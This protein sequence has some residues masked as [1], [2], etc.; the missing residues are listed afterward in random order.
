M[1]KKQNLVWRYGSGYGAP[2]D[3]AVAGSFSTRSK[4]GRREGTP[5]V[6]HGGWPQTATGFATC[7]AAEKSSPCPYPPAGND[8]PNPNQ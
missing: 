6:V 2:D 3:A 7:S 4:W 5:G 8:D 1:L